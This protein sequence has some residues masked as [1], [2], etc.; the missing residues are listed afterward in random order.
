MFVNLLHFVSRG[1]SSL[2]I[3]TLAAS[4]FHDLLELPA[5]CC[6]PTTVKLRTVL[7]CNILMLLLLMERNRT[8]QFTWR[9]I[10]QKKNFPGI[11]IVFTMDSSSV[12]QDVHLENRS[13]NGAA[14]SSEELLDCKAK[15]D[16]PV[17]TDE[18]NSKLLH[19]HRITSQ[20]YPGFS[21]TTYFVV[22][23]MLKDFFPSG[24]EFL[25][26]QF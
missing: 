2:V 13:S 11:W 25:V 6:T 14:S 16:L 3:T 18:I 4:C 15:S 8:W 23:V 5:A 26:Q 19:M 24:Q 10:I 12:Q 17:T 1:C 7:L 21:T 22:Q 9:Q 20:S